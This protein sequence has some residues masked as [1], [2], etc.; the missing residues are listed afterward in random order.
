[1]VE[2]EEDRL[3]DDEAGDHPIEGKDD[4][5]ALLIGSFGSYFFD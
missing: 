2:K 3:H 4:E 5:E 1:M